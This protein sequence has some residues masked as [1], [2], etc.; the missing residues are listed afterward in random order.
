MQSRLLER[1]QNR[2][3][4]R[5][6]HLLRLMVYEMHSYSTPL[7]PHVGQVIRYIVKFFLG[8]E[9]T[10]GS[11]SVLRKTSGIQFG[12]KEFLRDRTFFR[13]E[14]ELDETFKSD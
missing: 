7:S 5:M 9:H 1:Q 10:F 8:E 11:E 2:V 12:L 6:T 4:D 3:L 14:V 13:R